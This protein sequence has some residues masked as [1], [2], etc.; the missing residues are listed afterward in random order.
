MSALQNWQA[1]FLRQARSDWEAYQKTSEH[2]QK[3]LGLKK[4]PLHRTSPRAAIFK[5][6]FSRS[7]ALALLNDQMT[8]RV[9]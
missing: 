2:K 8:Q 4:S 3:P 7:L 5:K 1:A 6:I 9:E